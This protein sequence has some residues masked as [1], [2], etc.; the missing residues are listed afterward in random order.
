MKQ[1]T[2]HEYFSPDS[3]EFVCLLNQA[4]YS[5]RQAGY[6]WHDL[7]IKDLNELGLEP[8]ESEPCIFTNPDFS[9]YIM[10]YVDDI[11]A[12]GEDADVADIRRGLVAKRKIK[13]LPF[14]RFLRCDIIQEGNVI[15][16]N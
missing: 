7:C 2:S 4:L 3:V 8:L 15:F 10:I 14:E 9:V 6:L 12:T 1:L 5:L 13:E 16:V 11:L